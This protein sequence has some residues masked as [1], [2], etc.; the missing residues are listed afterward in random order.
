MSRDIRKNEVKK[1]SRSGPSVL[2]GLII[3]MIVSLFWLL[4]QEPEQNRKTRPA[5]PS[6]GKREHQEESYRREALAPTGRAETAELQVEAEPK[7]Q[8]APVAADRDDLKVVEGI[9][10]KTEVLLNEHGIMRLAQLAEADVENLRQILADA[11]FNL[12]VPDTWPEQ[13]RVAAGGST[14][15]LEELQDRIR[16]GRK[17]GDG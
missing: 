13:A 2:L 4:R 15:E 14:E 5:Q 1:S 9:G 6:E 10:E 7:Q 12:A 17:E 11:G 8:E 16:R 3:G